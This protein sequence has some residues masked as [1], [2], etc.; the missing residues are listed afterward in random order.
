M[1]KG[2]SYSFRNPPA[3][4]VGFTSIKGKGSTKKEGLKTNSTVKKGASHSKRK[5]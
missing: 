1:P 4:K 3:S 2:K 5:Y